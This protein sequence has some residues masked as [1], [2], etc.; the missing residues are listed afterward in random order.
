[1]CALDG[2]ETYLFLQGGQTSNG[3]KHFETTGKGK[4]SPARH[5]DHLLAALYLAKN[6]KGGP[7]TRLT[8]ADGAIT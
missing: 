1:V 5:G 3:T 2:V 8:A 4:G 6:L 7:R